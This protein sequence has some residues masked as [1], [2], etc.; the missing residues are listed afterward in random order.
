MGFKNIFLTLTM[1]VS[2]SSI[3]A[4]SSN[5]VEPASNVEKVSNTET[6][7]SQASSENAAAELPQPTLTRPSSGASQSTG[8]RL[9]IYIVKVAVSAAVTYF[10]TKAIVDYVKKDI[11]GED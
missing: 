1:I 8:A 9:T 4:C 7:N 11:T 5:R 6:E 2:L 3:T 10:V